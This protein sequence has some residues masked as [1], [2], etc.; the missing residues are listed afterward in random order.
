[1]GIKLDWEIEAEQ[2]EL[3]GGVN[4]GLGGERGIALRREG[5]GRG[6]TGR[7]VLGPGHPAA[8]LIDGEDRL[9][10]GQRAQLIAV[11]LRDVRNR[12]GDVSARTSA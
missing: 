9:I 6:E 3:V 2:A 5:I 7:N 8:F 1:M 12:R 10:A 4:P 11:S